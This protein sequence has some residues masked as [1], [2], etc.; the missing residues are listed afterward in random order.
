MRNPFHNRGAALTILA[1][2]LAGC[3]CAFQLGQFVHAADAPDKGGVTGS[4]KWSLDFGGGNAI[5][6]SMKAKQDGEKFT[7]KVH[8]GF[9]D[10]DMDIADGKVK[11][12]KISFKVERKLGDMT[13]T[14]NYT[15]TIDGDTIKG[16]D[17]AKIGDQEAQKVDWTAKRVP[18]AATQP[19]TKP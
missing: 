12:G 5:E 17:E 9:D 8:D 3:F 18:D 2:I 4:W 10:T 13:I 7:G 16:T 15:G 1:A 19:S 11:D 14:S 6:F